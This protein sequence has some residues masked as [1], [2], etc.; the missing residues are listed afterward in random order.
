MQPNVLLLEICALRAS[1]LFESE[2]TLMESVK[3]FSWSNLNEFIRQQ[4]LIQGVIRALFLYQA[5]A[6]TKQ[7]DVIPGSELRAAY[8]EA[9]KVP[10]C[11]IQLGDRPLEVT[12]K[13]V[14]ALL[15]VWQ[16]IRFVFTM[17]FSNNT[18]T[19]E[20]MEQLKTKDMLEEL[21]NKMAD[22]FAP[23]KQVLVDER[24]L[25]LAYNLQKA[26][27]RR[28]DSEFSAQAKKVNDS[29]ASF[30][31]CER[32]LTTCR[33]ELENFKKVISDKH[34]DA[35]KEQLRIWEQ[36]LYNLEQQ[37]NSK[38]QQMLNEEE[39]LSIMKSRTNEDLFVPSV[40]VGIVGIG[41]VAGIVRNWNKVKESDIFPIL[42]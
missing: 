25:V 11:E 5:K 34:V 40:V 18:I 36:K 21:I 33:N 28:P 3:N 30:L 26:A 10:G 20:E 22:S 2:E 39:K 4:G 16:K 6:I 12:L 19:T 7:L 24:D 38:Q 31:N 32:R 8:F 9:K 23:I 37:Y 29:L 35:Q 27:C 41:H 1:L 17:I 42:E 15:S 13:R 14:N